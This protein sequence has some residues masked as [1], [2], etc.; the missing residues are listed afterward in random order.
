MNR[1]VLLD[2]DGTLIREC[3][4][5]HDPELVRLERGVVPALQALHAAGF[6]LIVVTNQS[7]IGRGYYTEADF[8]A[9]QA[10]LAERLAEHDVPL[11]ATYHCPHHPTE[12]RGELRVACEC[13]KPRPGMVLAA[14]ADFDL[15]PA[16]SFLVGDTLSDVGA[17]QAAGIR[18]VL[19]RTGYGAEQAELDGPVVPDHVADD[20]ERA[21]RDYI[22][23]SA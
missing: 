12:A 7:G 13:R 20:L 19:V 14:I 4:Y 10:R 21:V 5:L 2:R 18:S 22:L 15:D 9:V 3:N 17:G 8:R 11:A 1:A 16:R 6:L 23:A